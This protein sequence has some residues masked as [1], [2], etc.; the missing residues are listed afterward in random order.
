MNA[1]LTRLRHEPVAFYG[2]V[3]SALL[4]ILA[5]IGVD[6]D[7]LATVVTIATLLGIPITRARV[8]PVQSTVDDTGHA[9]VHGV[10]LTAL[11]IAL[12][13]IVWSIIGAHTDL[14]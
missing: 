9:E 3:L 6:K 14:F 1:L 4:V 12:G 11:A 10:L 8:T 2:G 13:L 7:T 5:L